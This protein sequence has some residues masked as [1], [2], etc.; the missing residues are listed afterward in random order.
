M[1]LFAIHDLLPDTFIYHIFQYLPAV[2]DVLTVRAVCK[3][4]CHWVG[5]DYW[6]ERWRGPWPSIITGQ[7][8]ARDEFIIL[9]RQYGIEA[10]QVR[11]LCNVLTKARPNPNQRR[12]QSIQRRR[13]RR[14]W[15]H[16]C[17]VLGLYCY[18]VPLPGQTYSYEVEADETVVERQ[19]YGIYV[20]RNESEKPRVVA[21]LVA[22][23]QPIAQENRLLLDSTE[24][25]F[26]PETLER[27]RVEMRRRREVYLLNTR[28]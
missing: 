11:Y 16:L 5:Q 12:V 4:W 26:T 2:F 23:R 10:S 17:A 9:S 25:P 14:H 22:N 15:H 7:T 24:A 19:A 8:S 20:V 21:P 27:W 13:D 3:A 1:S 6:R 28:R 18:T